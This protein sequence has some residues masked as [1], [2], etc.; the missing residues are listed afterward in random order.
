MGPDVAR[1]PAR[2]GGA[3]ARIRRSGRAVLRGSVGARGRGPARRTQ[4]IE[5]CAWQRDSAGTRGAVRRVTVKIRAAGAREIV[6]PRGLPVT[7]HSVGR[8][9]GVIHLDR[10]EA[11][12]RELWQP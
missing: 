6:T 12:R 4:I 5:I 10:V 7:P 11:G 2:T 1:P 9:F 3:C 8:M